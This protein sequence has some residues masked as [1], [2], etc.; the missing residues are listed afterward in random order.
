[1][2]RVIILEDLPDAQRWLQESVLQAFPDATIRCFSMLKP[3]MAS[4]ESFIPHLCLVDLRLP[5]GNGV[6]FITRCRSL[7]PAAELIVTTMYD[8]DAHLF[9]ALKAGAN[10]YLL[11]EEPQAAIVRSLLAMD[12]GIPALSAPIAR[13]ILDHARNRM[14]AE[15]NGKTLQ[16]ELLS[17]REREFLV[18]IANGMKTADAA[19]QLGVSYHT[20][21]HHIKNIY[22]KLSIRS[23]AEAVQAA[24]QLGLLEAR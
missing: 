15:G 12:D 3:A 17:H 2:T 7:F 24:I 8:D 4:L 1:M 9:P 18:A 11:K 6:D 21:A 20:A 19:T 23:R 14:P 22:A 13:R 16:G 10:G 5:D